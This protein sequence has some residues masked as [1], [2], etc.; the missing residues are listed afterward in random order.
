MN[1]QQ[2]SRIPVASPQ[3]LPGNKAPKKR[4]F[5]I[6]LVIIF[7]GLLFS[8]VYFW[9]KYRAAMK[10]PNAAAQ[11]EARAI[12]EKIQKFM[13]LPEGETPDLAKVSNKEKLESQ[14]F[15]QKAQNGDVVLIYL[16]AKKA[17]LYRPSTNRVIDMVPL[18]EN[19]IPAQ[20]P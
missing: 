19:E 7:A 14:P 15:F 16:K 6:V 13:D 2:P 1:H 17:I 10:N 4:L 11:E 20:N 3:Q 9:Q 8:T 12:T 18:R 5:V